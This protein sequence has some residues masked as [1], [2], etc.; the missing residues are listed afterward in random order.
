MSWYVDLV[1]DGKPVQVEPHQAGCMQVAELRGDELV[2]IDRTDASCSVT[3]NYSLLFGL[4]GF[5]I[6]DMH[7][8]KASETIESLKSA[9]EKLGTRR[10]EDYWKETP[11]NAGAALE[12][13][14]HWA[15]QY[16]DATWEV[17]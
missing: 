7:G 3:Y 9:V 2:A 4:A 8:K 13:L 16:P 5:D 10:D 6:R 17:R 12:S 1:V 14:L 15:Q 11:G